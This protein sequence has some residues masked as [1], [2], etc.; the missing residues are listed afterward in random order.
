MEK[1][2]RSQV[3]ESITIEI[4]YPIHVIKKLRIKKN[5]PCTNLVNGDA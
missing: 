1:L 4:Y 3:F 2:I 5:Y